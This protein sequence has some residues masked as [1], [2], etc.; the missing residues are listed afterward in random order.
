MEGLVAGVIVGTSSVWL[1]AALS[2][3]WLEG[4]EA[5]ALGLAVS[6]AA[7]LGDLF[8]SLVKRSVGAKDSGRLLGPHG[9]LL[10]RI[11]AALFAAV[12]GYYAGLALT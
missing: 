9:G 1:F 7:P 6:V 12:A 4:W 11:D 8:E 5:L 2:Q 10:D 3:E